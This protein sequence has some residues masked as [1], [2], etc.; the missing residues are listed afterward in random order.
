MPGQ[1][2]EAAL[3]DDGWL[4]VSDK[5]DYFRLWD[6]ATGSLAGQHHGT[7]LQLLRFQPGGNKLMAASGGGI[8]VFALPERTGR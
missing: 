7:Y 8:T 2:V 1:I 6:V 5:D 4:A 3:S